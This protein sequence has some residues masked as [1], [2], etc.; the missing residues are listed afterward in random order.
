MKRLFHCADADY[1]VEHQ[2]PLKV[3]AQYERRYGPAA[4]RELHEHGITPEIAN[5]APP[6][7]NASQVIAHHST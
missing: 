6:G 1:L 4:I 5:T 2:V 7:M 3:A